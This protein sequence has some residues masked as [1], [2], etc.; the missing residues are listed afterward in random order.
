MGILKN[1]LLILLISVLFFSCSIGDKYK[2][3]ETFS[4]TDINNV[5]QL[6]GKTLFDEAVIA[7]PLGIQVFDSVLI[8]LESSGDNIC[9]LFDLKNQ[10]IIGYRLKRGQGPNE[11]IMP[12]WVNG[13]K[14]LLRFIDLASATIYEYNVNEFINKENPYFI[15]KVNLS[16][17][18]DSEVHMI[19][20]DYVGYRYFQ[21]K[22][23]YIY[24]KDGKEKNSII[25]FP[26]S[27]I[28][29]SD[30]E[31]TNAYYMGF[32]SNN[33]DRIAVCYYMTDLIEIYNDKGDMLKRLHGP[34]Q[35]FAHI[36]GSSSD[37]KDAYFSPESVGD[38]F[39]VLYNGGRISDQNH[40]S[41]CEKLFSFS[42]NGSLQCLYQLDVP[43]YTF[44]VDEQTKKIYGI[45]PKP[46]YHI[47]E[48]S[49]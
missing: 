14:D 2:N 8:V 26:E 23:L 25:D 39:F 20:E 9:Q 6:K 21:D 49:Y 15:N 28:I 47:V 10:T 17:N 34:E 31:K 44:C 3:A 18:V 12:Y 7:S 46:E 45:C 19:N 43:I 32:V 36:S 41:S 11:M 38:S 16:G 30:E 42:W 22:Q 1:G 29:Y 33:K 37:G 4:F 40:S 35:F 27:N 24:D 5:M 48:Y 13:E